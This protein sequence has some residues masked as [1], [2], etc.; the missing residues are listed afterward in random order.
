MS[1]HHYILDWEDED[2]REL[3]MAAEVVESFF[4]PGFEQCDTEATRARIVGAVQSRSERI[5]HY[6]KSAADSLTLFPM[7]TIDTKEYPYAEADICFREEAVK[8]FWRNFPDLPTCLYSRSVKQGIT[9]LGFAEGVLYVIALH[10]LGP[11][12]V[13]PGEVDHG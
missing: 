2:G 3:L 9:V 5:D 10:D 12:P 6:Y 7:L 1:S 8:M 13:G 4:E 11:V